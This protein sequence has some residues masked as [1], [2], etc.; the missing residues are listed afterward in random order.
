MRAFEI[1]WSSPEKKMRVFLF[2]FTEAN[3]KSTDR[4][5]AHRSRN[6]LSSCAQTTVDGCMKE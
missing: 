1:V 4:A 3:A 5:L 2:E 6:L